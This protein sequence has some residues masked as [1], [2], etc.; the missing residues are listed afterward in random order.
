MVKSARLVVTGLTSATALF[1]LLSAPAAAQDEKKLREYFEG[2][3]VT[4]RMDMPGTSDGIDL[5]VDPPRAIDYKKYRENLKRYGVA[6]GSG[7]TSTI[8]L[9]KLKKDLIEFQLGGGGYGTFGDDTSTSSGIHLLD[10]S[11]R[12][13]DLEKRIKETTDKDRKRA[14]QR[15]LDDL[16][17]RREN[18]NRVLQAESERIEEAKKARL[19]ER[20]LQGGSRFNLK[21][22]PKVPLDIQP[23][24]IEK[25]LVEYVDFRNAGPF[26]DRR[27]APADLSAVRK[28]MARDEAEAMFGKPVERSEKREGGVTVTTLVFDVGEQRLTAAFVEDV[29]IRYTISSR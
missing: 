9:I 4:L 25:A 5:Q 20:R 14:L 13:K 8:T 6:I 28:G 21:W 29:L 12:E 26:E 17:R 11:D 10:K 2:R 7:E 3:R 22:S 24:D 27:P 18:E 23:G 19:A 16:R 1:T 15:E